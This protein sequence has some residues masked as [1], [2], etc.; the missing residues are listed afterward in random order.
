M[1]CSSELFQTGRIVGRK[2]GAETLEK[3]HFPPRILRSL[4]SNRVG[5]EVVGDFDDS[6]KRPVITW[7]AGRA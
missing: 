4:L 1:L 5:A 7:K 2:M 3:F 6:P